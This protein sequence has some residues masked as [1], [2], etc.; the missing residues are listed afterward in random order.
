M[1]FGR[2]IRVTLGNIVITD[3]DPAA[4][5]ESERRSLDCTFTTEA[6]TKLEPLLTEATIYG[7][8]KITRD[9]LIQQQ[10]QAASRSWQEYQKVLNR[11]LLIE[12]E[13]AVQVQQ[14]LSFQGLQLRIEAGYEGD[15]GL[16]A[17]ATT[18]PDGIKHRYDGNG[19]V[20]TIKAQDNRYPWQNGFVNEPVAP[21]VTLRD[22]DLITQLSEGYLEGDIAASV[23]QE[24]TPEL[25][26]RKDF[27]GYINGGILSGQTRDVRTEIANALGLTA[28]FDRGQLV[29]LNLNA[30]TQE[31]AVLLQEKG[32]AGSVPTPSPGG[33]LEWEEQSRGYISARCLLNYKLTAGR[34]VIMQD[35]FGDPI[36][37]GVFRIDHV[38]HA[39]SAIESTYNSEVLLRPTA[40]PQA[41]NV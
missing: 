10:K 7:I 1:Q 25:L 2:R 22:M 9:Q 15:F 40:I 14:Q 41:L 17:N 23:I 16:I 26:V 20:T 34:Q 39:G 27:A 24:Q 35:R 11:S 18:L 21:G 38:R 12:P 31:E 33:L 8:N 28:F 19:Y 30:V 32:P 29:Y 5:M 36:G 37:V 13:S 6:H 3:I 4:P